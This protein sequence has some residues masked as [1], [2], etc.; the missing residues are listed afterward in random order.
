MEYSS[1]D[2][3]SGSPLF[4]LVSLLREIQTVDIMHARAG[5]DVVDK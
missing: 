3:Y 4:S 5:R 2:C 1:F